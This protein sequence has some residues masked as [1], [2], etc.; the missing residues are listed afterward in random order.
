LKKLVLVLLVATLAFGIVGC[1]SGPKADPSKP[2]GLVKAFLDAA[3][4]ADIQ[5]QNSLMSDR[6]AAR[7]KEKNEY[8]VTEEAKARGAKA[9]LTSINIKVLDLRENTSATVEAKYTLNDNDGINVNTFGIKE[10][11][12]LQFTNGKWVIVDFTRSKSTL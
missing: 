3:A 12:Q 1:S 2:D 7:F 5:K 8:L 4:A 9:N 10:Q 6:L 11:Y